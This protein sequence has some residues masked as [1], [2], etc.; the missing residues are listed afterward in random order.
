MLLFRTESPRIRGGLKNLR[1]LKTTKSSFTDFIQD[2]YR[3][4]PDADDRI[5]STV[6]TASWQFSTASGVNFDKVW[7]TVKNCILENFAGPP[8]SGINS[9]SVQNTL[10]LAEKCVLSKISQVILPVTQ[11]Y[12]E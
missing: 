2:D 9:P 10:Y 7:Q 8:E 6:V 3:T 5:F 4:L 1:V 11:D 12:R